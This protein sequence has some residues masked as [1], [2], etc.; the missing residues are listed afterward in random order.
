MSKP[1]RLTAPRILESDRQSQIIDWLRVEQAAGRVSWFARVNSGAIKAGARWIVNY[2]LYLRG[3]TEP[4]SKGYADLHGMLSDGRYFAL[5]V[6]QPGEKATEE[7]L[8][9]LMSVV[10]A[11]GIADVVTGFED[12]EK[13]LRATKTPLEGGV[14][15][16][17]TAG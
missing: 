5:E 12:V 11:G 7:Q 15:A 6:K 9:F 14:H 17:V 2:R 1:F 3:I 4:R 8:C 13:V 16:P 10:A